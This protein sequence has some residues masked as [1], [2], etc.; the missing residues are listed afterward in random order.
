M[1]SRVIKL[2]RELFDQ[3]TKVTSSNEVHCIMSQRLMHRCPATYKFGMAL[4]VIKPYLCMLLII[5]NS[6]IVLKYLENYIFGSI[7]LREY[8]IKLGSESE[9]APENFIS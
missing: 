2:L 3:P 9:A 4:H 6:R 5:F 1:T 8:M 7:N